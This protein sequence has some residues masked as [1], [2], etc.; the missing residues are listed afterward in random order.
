MKRKIIYIMLA[1]E[2]VVLSLLNLFSDVF[3]STFSSLLAFPFEQV[4]FLLRKLSLSGSIGNGIALV[5]WVITCL[6]PLVPV[7]PHLREKDRRLEHGTLALMSILLFSV[8]HYM[9]NPGKLITLVP[10][11]TIETLP[12]LKAILGITVWSV[13][14]CYIIFRLLRLFKNSDKQ[15]LFIYL[16]NLLYALC[17]LFVGVIALSCV[18]TLIAEQ[19]N[20]TYSKDAFMTFCRFIVTTLPY[21]LELLVT[22]TALNLLDELLIDSHSEKV[23]EAAKRLSSLCCLS[24]SAIAVAEVVLNLLQ[25]V[26]AK[27]LSNLNVV[28]DIP[29]MN[30]A[31]VLVALLLARLLIENK[32]L[33]D[34]NDMFI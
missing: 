23:V 34:D 1:F 22:L 21:V 14:V 3:P 5:I 11:A 33:A 17:F 4:G 30:L 25:L 28:A 32:K 7:L 16:K 31:F 20:N 24:L 13:V 10:L 9:I 2:L 29:L 12:A 18:G 6:L 26:M 8:L 19:Q 27:S 15:S